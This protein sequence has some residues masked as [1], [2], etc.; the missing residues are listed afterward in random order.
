MIVEAIKFHHNPSEAIKHTEV[1]LVIYAADTIDHHIKAAIGATGPPDFEPL[2]HLIKDGIPV[3]AIVKATNSL[4]EAW[5][6]ETEDLFTLALG[7]T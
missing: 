2:D 3:E 1:A 5:A 7:A 4:C 6:A